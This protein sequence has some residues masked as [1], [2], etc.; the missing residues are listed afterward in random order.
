[1]VGA[2]PYVYTS[3][4]PQPEHKIKKPNCFTVDIHC[5]VHVPEAAEIAEAHFTPD[6]EPS[7]LF[8]G[9]LSRQI[10]QGDGF[11]G[12]PGNVTVRTV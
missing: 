3:A 1:M 5:H 10:N 4:R 7:M 2:Q 11:L 8:A 6:M 9:E 12:A